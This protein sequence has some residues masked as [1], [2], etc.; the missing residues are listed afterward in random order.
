MPDS[1][2][3]PDLA[4]V[5]GASIVGLLTSPGAARVVEKVI[6]GGDGGKRVTDAELAET[7]PLLKPAQG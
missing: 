4:H 7:A 6:A 1:C 5:F 3:L 2:K